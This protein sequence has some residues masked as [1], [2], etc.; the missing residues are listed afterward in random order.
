MSHESTIIVRTLNVKSDTTCTNS[1]F[2]DLQKMLSNTKRAFV[3]S[4][5]S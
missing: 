3:N 1:S 4:V 2:E 5:K